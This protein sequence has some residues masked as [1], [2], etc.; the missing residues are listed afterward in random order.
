[1]GPTFNLSPV[2][3]PLPP[4]TP[5]AVPRPW[6]FYP[7]D[8]ATDSRGRGAP[9]PSGSRPAGAGARGEPGRPWLQ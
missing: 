3:V 5:G 9:V 7:A 6:P 4:T 8:P 1:M 2:V